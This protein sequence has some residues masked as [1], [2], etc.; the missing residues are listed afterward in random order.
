MRQNPAKAAEAY[1]ISSK[2]VPKKTEP[3]GPDMTSLLPK[4]IEVLKSGDIT[5]IKGFLK[6]NAGVTKA[7]F[8]NGSLKTNTLNVAVRA[9]PASE[10]RIE[11]FR[12]LVKGGAGADFIETHVNDPGIAYNVVSYPESL[13]VEELDFLLGAGA[14]PDCGVCVP[15][16]PPILSL[17]NM[18]FGEKGGRDTT[19]TKQEALDRIKVFVKHKA[20][21]AKLT[22]IATEL[23]VNGTELKPTS[24][25]QL[26]TESGCEELKSALGLK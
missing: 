8:T 14:D 12:L 7:T 17:C 20:N 4:L 9:V 5:T 24:A 11:V 10:E 23:T 16:T 1:L 2:G 19:L 15:K 3:P 18:M 22:G 26:A 25:A 13:T 6:Q 21:P